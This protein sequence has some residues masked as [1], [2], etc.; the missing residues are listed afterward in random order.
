[1]SPILAGR[2]VKG[3]TAKMMNE[4]G[5]PVA[6]AA[7]AR[8]YGDILDG[9]VVDQSEAGNVACPGIAVARAATMMTTLADREDLGRDVLAFAD[10]LRR[11]RAEPAGAS[12]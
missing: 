9:Y 5:L 10:S 8:R 7:V 4:L 3:P 6:A 2:A 1:M 11:S 12:A